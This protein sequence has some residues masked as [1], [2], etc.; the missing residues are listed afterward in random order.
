[1]EDFMNKVKNTILVCF[2]SFALIGT[3]INAFVGCDDG[4]GD[5]CS[6]CETNADCNDDL[7]CRTY[8]LVGQVWQLCGNSS[9]KECRVFKTST[10][11]YVTVKRIEGV[12]HNSESENSSITAP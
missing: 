5:E 4:A 1:M 9:T 7:T 8:T 2:L 12:Q 6:K 3:V 11:E 10:Q